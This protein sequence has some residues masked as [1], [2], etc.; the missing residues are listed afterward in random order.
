ML[1]AG[2][3]CMPLHCSNSYSN[4]CL[5]NAFLLTTIQINIGHDMWHEDLE[6]SSS[7]IIEVIVRLMFIAQCTVR[8]V[9]EK[10][11]V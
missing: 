10:R 8:G 1:S 4:N 5:V 2:N 7:I 6:S 11:K 9:W 3:K